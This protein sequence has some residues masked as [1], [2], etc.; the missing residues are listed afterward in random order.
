MDELIETLTEYEFEDDEVIYVHRG[1][2][3]CNHVM[4][5]CWC[6]P[7]ELTLDDI[8]GYTGEELRNLLE[9]FLSLH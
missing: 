4:D 6:Y 1:P 9:T 2:E 3:E 7:L 5:D 8:Q